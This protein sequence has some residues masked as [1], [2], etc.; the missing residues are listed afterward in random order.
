ML[1]VQANVDAI[2]SELVI[3]RKVCLPIIGVENKKKGI[4]VI[5]LLHFFVCVSTAIDTGGQVFG[6]RQDSCFVP[7]F[8][9]CRHLWRR[10]HVCNK[11]VL[12]GN[13]KKPSSVEKKNVHE[14]NT[15]IHIQCP[16]T[17]T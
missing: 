6:Q 8:D 17:T 2:D 10:G 1:R 5:N 12:T 13:Q 11:K 15:Q 16:L 3:A 9:Q 4:F 14:K 7:V